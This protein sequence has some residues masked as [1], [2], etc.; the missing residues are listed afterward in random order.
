MNTVHREEPER[1]FDVGTPERWDRPQEPVSGWKGQ[2]VVFGPAQTQGSKKGFLHPKLK[3]VMIVDDND[4]ALKGWRSE[5]VGQMAQC[6]PER[7]IDS[8]VAISILV[9]VKRPSSHYGSGKNAGALKATAPVIPPSGKD[10]DKICRAILDAGQIA[11]WYTNDARVSDL[12]IKRRYD[13]GIERVIV[14][15]WSLHSLTQEPPDFGEPPV[16]PEAEAF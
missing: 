5:W 14:S 11:G 12:Q 1:L 4:H 15:G 7:P 9:Y 6:R 8:A 2:A 3:R 16:E 13:E 10:N